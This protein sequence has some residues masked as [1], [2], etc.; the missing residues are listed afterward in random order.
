[1]RKATTQAVRDHAVAE[2][3]REACGLIV[4]AG[5]REVYVPCRNLAMGADHFV[6]S[7][8]DYAAAEDVGRIAAV[9]HS[10]PDVPPVPSEADRVACEATGMPWYI[11]TVAK[12]PEGNVVA[13]EI[14]G[15]TPVGYRA[16]LLG[17]Q[18]A[19]GVLDCYSLVRDWYE[20]ERGIALPDFSRQDGWWE[21]GR[22]GDLYMDHYAEAGFR[23]LAL[24]EVMEP[25]DVV[26]MQVRSDRANHAGIYLGMERIKEAPEVHPVPDA[27]LHHLHGRQS[28]RVVYGGYWL[29][30]TR[31]VLRYHVAAANP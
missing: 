1:M 15:F 3:P 11:V 10:H 21:P 18:F 8:E 22:D 29:E 17:R 13:G 9:V 14:R 16:P 12:G 26:I 28:E 2:Y 4:M 5:K 27:M 19:H 31:L 23:P 7:P 25:G 20:R 6:M 24:G 30:A